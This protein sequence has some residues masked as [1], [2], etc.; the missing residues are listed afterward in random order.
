MNEHVRL[1]LSPLEPDPERWARVMAAT[2]VRADGALA[3]RPA[4]PLATIASWRRPLLVAAA[5]AVAVLVPVE[6]ALE[7]REARAEQV[8]RLV[9]LSARRGDNQPPPTGA[10]FLRALTAEETP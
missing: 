3:R 4:D 2:L 7:A 9:T 5:V 6:F 8:E 10:E 1:D